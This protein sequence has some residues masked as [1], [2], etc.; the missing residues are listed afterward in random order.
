[1][2]LP[3]S[4]AALIGGQITPDYLSNFPSSNQGHDLMLL[5]YTHIGHHNDLAAK[6]EEEFNT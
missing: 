2:F 3:R 6:E 4:C 5:D 1:M